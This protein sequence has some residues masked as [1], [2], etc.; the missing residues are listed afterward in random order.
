MQRLS[1]W[2][3]LSLSWVLYTCFLAVDVLILTLQDGEDNFLRQLSLFGWISVGF[4]TYGGVVHLCLSVGLA[5]PK[6]WIAVKKSLIMCYLIYELCMFL[7]TLGMVT[8]LLMTLRGSSYAVIITAFFSITWRVFIFTYFVV[9]IRFLKAHTVSS[10]PTPA[11]RTMIQVPAAVVLE[12]QPAEAPLTA[13]PSAPTF[14]D[15]FEDQFMYSN[16]YPNVNQY[17]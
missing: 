1:K 2:I 8:Y 15:E 4:V 10:A 16:M 14:P 17:I 11:P 9:Y 12:E 3:I 13:V 7:Y 6:R 5:I